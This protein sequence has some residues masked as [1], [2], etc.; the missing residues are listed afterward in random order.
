MVKTKI[1]LFTS[2]HCVNCRKLKK[3][4]PK[5]LSQNGLHME[6]VLERNVEDATALTD[7]IM[8]D[9]DLIPTLHIGSL[10]LTGEATAD[11]AKLDAFLKTSLKQ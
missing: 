4:L 6:D 5:I 11:E 7:L 2:E 1:E 10:I 3:I 8:L 9:T